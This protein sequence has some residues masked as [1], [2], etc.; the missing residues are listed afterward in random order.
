[1]DEFVH[2][3]TE[4]ALDLAE[5]L[6]VDNATLISKLKPIQAGIEQNL[7]AAMASIEA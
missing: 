4:A 1:M 6:P 7:A 3:I 2:L 5:G